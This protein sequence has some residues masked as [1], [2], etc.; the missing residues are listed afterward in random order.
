M[1]ANFETWRKSYNERRS[2]FFKNQER[3]AM[4]TNNFAKSEFANVLTKGGANARK[5]K[6]IMNLDSININNNY[7][8]IRLSKAITNKNNR[9]AEALINLGAPMKNKNLL[10]RAEEQKMSN[11]VINALK[12]KNNEIKKANINSLVNRVSKMPMSELQNKLPRMSANNKNLIKKHIN[13]FNGNKKTF[14]NK[15]INL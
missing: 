11:K 2:N 8:D 5:L 6:Y 15:Y 3:N 1:N 13:R 7:L 4:Y 14:I 9:A 12:K 10:S